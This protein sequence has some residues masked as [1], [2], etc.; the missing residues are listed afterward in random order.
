MN[1][2]N[3]MLLRDLDDLVLGK[4]C[5]NRGELPSL[6]DD[7][8]LVGL[9]SVHTKPILVAED[10]DG[11]EGE[12]VGGTEDADRDLAAVGDCERQIRISHQRTTRELGEKQSYPGS[13]SIA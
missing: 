3:A 1:Q 4:V 7:V 9:L 5:G 8:G 10:G 11:M 6:A 12:L 2:I 13:S